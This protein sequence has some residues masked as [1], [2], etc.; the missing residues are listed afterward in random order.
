MINYVFGETNGVK[1][2]NV[3]CFSF[4]IELYLIDNVVL[5]SGIWK[6]DSDIYIFSRSFSII[7]YYKILNAVPCV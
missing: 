6:S 5:V 2:Q 3:W 7:G 1:I 4:F